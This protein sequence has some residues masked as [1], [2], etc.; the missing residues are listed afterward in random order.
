MQIESSRMA[1]IPASS[2]VTSPPSMREQGEDFSQALK[3]RRD[4]V[5]PGDNYE[6]G[7]PPPPDF[8]QKLANTAAST[9]KSIF[10]IDQPAGTYLG[11]HP[12]LPG[13]RAPITPNQQN[14]WLGA[15]APYAM[16]VVVGGVVLYV[17]YRAGQWYYSQRPDD[18]QRVAPQTLPL[19]V[20]PDMQTAD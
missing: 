17:A 3:A 18:Y 1:K 16:P 6:F 15:A 4:G 5:R 2:G 14:T 11:A 10:K 9:W 13:V 8:W 19:N 7:Q 20:L 12:N